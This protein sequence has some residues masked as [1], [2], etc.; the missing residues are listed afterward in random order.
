MVFSPDPA[1]GAG[2]EAATTVK[3]VADATPARDAV[4]AVVAR[5]LTFRRRD[6]PLP[7][8][9]DL[10]FTVPAGDRCAVIGPSGCGKTTLLHC[11]AGLL[12]STGGELAVLGAPPGRAGARLAL[13]FQDSGLLPWKTV[14]GN[15]QLGPAVRGL[16]GKAQAE[17]ARRALDALG[18]WELRDR[19]PSEL[20]GGQRQRVALARVLAQR[21]ELLLLDEPFSALDALTREALQVFLLELWRRSGCAVVIVTHGIE[22]AVFLGRRILVLT[23]PPARLAAVVDNPRAGDPS[24]RQSAAFHRA[25]VEVRAALA[26]ASRHVG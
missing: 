22:E 8:F 20:S 23:P 16:R 6:A 24:Y 19:Y 9:Q 25:C 1:A 4:P 15:V 7:V 13:L 18:L 5:H 21:P 17:E 3:T 14:L 10:T 12:P 11:L 26:E 2:G